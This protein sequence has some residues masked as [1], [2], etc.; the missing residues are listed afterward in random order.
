MKRAL[1]ACALSFSTLGTRRAAASDSDPWFGRDKA[2]HFG[3]SVVLAAGGYATSSIWL[4]HRPERALAGGAFSLTLGAGKELW[5]LSGHG[6]P[7]W[8]DFTWDVIGTGV[9][10]ALAVAGDALLSS[11]STSAGVHTSTQ[12]LVFRF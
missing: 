10:V 12:G 2:L 1:I 5:D 8:R 3:V 9:G 6:D 11:K 4:E 7:S